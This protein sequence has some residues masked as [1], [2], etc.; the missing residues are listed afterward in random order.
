MIGIVVYAGVCLFAT[1][2]NSERE[3]FIM[4][5]VVGLV[6]G[7]VRRSVV[8]TSPASFRR[9]KAGSVSASITCLAS[10]P[11][12]L[13]PLLMGIATAVVTDSRTCTSVSCFSSAA[14][15]RYDEV[16]ESAPARSPDVMD[17]F[18]LACAY[19]GVPARRLLSRLLV[20]ATA[21]PRGCA[22]PRQQHDRHNQFSGTSSKGG[23]ALVLLL[24]ALKGA[25]AVVVARA[26]G[27]TGGWEFAAGTAV[28]AGHVWPVQLR[29]RGGRG[30]GPLLGA[31]LTLAPPARS[32]C[33]VVVAR[34]PLGDLQTPDVAGLLGTLLLR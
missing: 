30:L 16:Q 13:G 1:R 10:S 6:Q 14:A 8:P 34:C 33:T 12:I 29:F 25:L 21:H 19:R 20:G 11:A 5:G 2:M 9:K 26:A 27:L 31:W 18:A 4:A 15:C 22:D 24:D 28:V 3:F 17:V 23:S 7:G 32:A